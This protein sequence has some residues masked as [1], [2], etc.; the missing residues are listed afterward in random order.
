MVKTDGNGYLSV[1]YTALTPLLVEA[2]KEQQKTIETQTAVM[3][4]MQKDIIV[5]K[6]KA[7]L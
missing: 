6:K 4:A 7:G 2:I 5:L 1:N 3:N